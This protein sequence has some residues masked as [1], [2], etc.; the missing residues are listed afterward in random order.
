MSVRPHSVREVM[1][2]QLLRRR[3][4]AQQISAPRHAN[5]ADVVGELGAVQAQD[6]PGAQWAVALRTT[7][8]TAQAL[9]RAI[10]SATVVRT[11]PMRGT[12]HLVAAADV[13]WMLQLLSPRPLAN[14]RGRLRQLQLSD[15]D[16]QRGREAVCAALAGGG[17][18]TRPELYSVLSAAG[19]DPVGQRGIHVLGWLAHHAVICHGPAAGKQPTFVLLDEWVAPE[20][21]VERAE[22]LTRLALR[23]FTGHGPAT[24]HDLAWWSGLAMADARAAVSQARGMLT[25]LCVGDVE[26]WSGPDLPAPVR[27]PRVQLLPGFDEYLLGYRDR[28]AMLGPEHAQRIVP[29]NNGMFLPMIVLDGRV[30]G[31]WRRVQGDQATGVGLEW[32]SAPT[33]VA[34]A[35]AVA[36]A[37]RYARFAGLPLKLTSSSDNG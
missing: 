23:Y 14:M 4:L 36:A 31:R 7:G 33:G 37:R 8:G 17:R 11:W 34:R 2:R 10:A 25:H 24:A 13:R 30:A 20:P 12:L 6:W 28:S 29:G 9:D 26:Y 1:V 19:V 16:L 21:P 27:T 35:A 18:L 3:L 22:A 15:A 32:F 5:A